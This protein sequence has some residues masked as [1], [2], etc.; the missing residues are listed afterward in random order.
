MCWLTMYVFWRM[1]TKISI[2]IEMYGYCSNAE[3]YSGIELIGN[4]NGDKSIIDT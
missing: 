2:D 1:R 3:G 4:K